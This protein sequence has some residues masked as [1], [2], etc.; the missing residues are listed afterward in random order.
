MQREKKLF[1]QLYKIVNEATLGKE[2]RIDFFSKRET[3]VLPYVKR[4]N[5]NAINVVASTQER[6]NVR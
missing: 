2:E 4:E 3:D 6:S 1:N 5:L